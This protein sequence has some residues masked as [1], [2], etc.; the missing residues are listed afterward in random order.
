MILR[1]FMNSHWVVCTPH[2]QCYKTHP[3]DA[4]CYGVISHFKAWSPPPPHVCL[5]SQIPNLRSS[6]MLPSTLLT[7]RLWYITGAVNVVSS[8]H[9]QHG[10]PP[11]RVFCFIWLVFLLLLVFSLQPTVTGWHRDRGCHTTYSVS[12]KT[13]EELLAYVTTASRLTCYHRDRPANGNS[14]D[15]YDVDC[16][17]FVLRGDLFF[18]PSSPPSSV[19]SYT[20]PT[21]P[22]H[23]HIHTHLYIKHTKA[24][25]KLIFCEMWC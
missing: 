13:A 5:W 1:A 4:P 16:K 2:D 19:H 23:V 6:F 18:S 7:G 8:S 11:P 20:D 15:G 21:T 3:G 22:T 25:L 9:L 14:A 12:S 10:R 17:L 24:L